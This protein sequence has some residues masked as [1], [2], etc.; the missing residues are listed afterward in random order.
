[1]KLVAKPE[2]FELRNKRSD[3]E[4]DAALWNPQD[5]LYDASQEI[6]KQEVDAC[7]VI[8]RERHADDSMEVHYRIAGPEGS[9]LILIMKALGR[10][11]N[12]V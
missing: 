1:M 7:I 9:A 8:W 11:M 5:A 10:L 6:A 3:K 12:W 4:R 2:G